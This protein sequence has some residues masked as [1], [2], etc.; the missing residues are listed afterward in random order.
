[1]QKYNKSIHLTKTMS[2]FSDA[3]LLAGFGR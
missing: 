3:V 1:M 2:D